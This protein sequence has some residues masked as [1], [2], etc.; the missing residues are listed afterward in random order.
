MTKNEKIEKKKR[1]SAPLRKNT[2]VRDEKFFSK[3]FLII[4]DLLGHEQLKS[5]SNIE[6]SFLTG[7]TLW[8]PLN[9]DP[10]SS[11][12]KNMKSAAI[13]QI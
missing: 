3:R 9:F 10:G 12:V 11:A 5:V 6:S 13:S 8:A 4:V 7:Y 2:Y 1:I